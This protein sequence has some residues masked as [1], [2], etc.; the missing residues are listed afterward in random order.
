MIENSLKIAVDPIFPPP[1]LH[2]NKNKRQPYIPDNILLNNLY[3]LIF[4]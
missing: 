1:D 2:F 3:E 4:D